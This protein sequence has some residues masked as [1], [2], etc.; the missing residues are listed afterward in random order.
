MLDLT[1]IFTLSLFHLKES[2]WP[3]VIPENPHGLFKIKVVA[4]TI[5]MIL[6]VTSICPIQNNNSSGP[7][8]CFFK[9][10]ILQKSFLHFQGKFGVWITSNILNSIAMFLFLLRSS[11]I[12]LGKFVTEIHNSSLNVRSNSQIN[13]N[14][15]NVLVMIDDYFRF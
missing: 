3:K 7:K 6:M 12:R 5:L 14:L 11:I 9:K 10:S 2:F 15:K 13:P 4:F 1:V 8:I